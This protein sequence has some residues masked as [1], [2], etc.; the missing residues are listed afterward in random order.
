MN[1]QDFVTVEYKSVTG[2]CKPAAILLNYIS[3]SPEMK[4]VGVLR[5]PVVGDICKAELVSAKVNA[6]SGDPLSDYSI[7]KVVGVSELKNGSSALGILQ[8]A[9]Q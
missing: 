5:V 3:L 1:G 9:K 6:P 4:Q 2:S 7:V 8:P